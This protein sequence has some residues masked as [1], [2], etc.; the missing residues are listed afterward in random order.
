M[1]VCP[2][3]GGPLERA[4]TS[5]RCARGHTF[6]LARQGYLGL[7]T[8]GMRVGTADN[9][10]MVEARDS[11]LRAGHYAPLA[12][13]LAELAAPLCP[14]GGTVLDA[15]VGTGYYLAALLDATPGAVG[16]GLDAS[17]YALRRA[18][19]A[20]GRAS[21]ATWDV[22]EP[23]PVREGAVDVLLNVFAPRNGPEFRRVL[24]PG[25]ALVVVTPTARH[26]AELQQR[27]GTLSVDTAKEDRLRRTLA[28]HF[29]S[30]HTE[31]L[32]YGLALPAHDVE[33]AVAMG[34]S[35]HHLEAGEAAR[36]TAELDAPFTVTA[37]F[38][39]SVYQPN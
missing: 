12:R 25:G 26:L 21:A 5:L 9:A 8:G 17:K 29:R 24:R 1:L 31:S 22:W 37:S 33:N 20:H 11:F 10:A 36:R 35:S 38:T 32:E 34:P 15:G 19:R 18:A 30:E 39:L 2:L 28:D 27:M 4:A 16:L 3:C 23:L 6:D 13:R 14:P 7:L